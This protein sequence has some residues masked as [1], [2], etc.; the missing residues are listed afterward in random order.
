MEKKGSYL[1]VAFIY[2]AEYSMLNNIV[3]I[4]W[5]TSRDLEEDPGLST[6]FQLFF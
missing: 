4:Q 3:Y 5:Q 6:Y 2:I 1:C